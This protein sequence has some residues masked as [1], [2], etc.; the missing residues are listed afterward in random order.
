MFL[1][2]RILVEKEHE[3]ISPEK[4]CFLQSNIRQ[5]MN[6]V[7]YDRTRR[8]FFERRAILMTLEPV[9]H[10]FWKWEWVHELQV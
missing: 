8:G 10:H 4:N 1:Y 3:L 2:R 6:C 5:S 9:L 7:E